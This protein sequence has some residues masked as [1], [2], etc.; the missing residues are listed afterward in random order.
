MLR[1]LRC[2]TYRPD[3]RAQRV[4]EKSLYRCDIT[5]ESVRGARRWWWAGDA[6]HVRHRDGACSAMSEMQMSR[7][8]LRQDTALRTS[9]RTREGRNSPEASSHEPA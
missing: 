5:Q 7:R 9:A 6:L 1:H 4:S 8:S 3:R 2:A